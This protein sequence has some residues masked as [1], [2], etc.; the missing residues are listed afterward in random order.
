MIPLGHSFAGLVVVVA[1]EIGAIIGRMV[2]ED[3]FSGPITSAA[4]KSAQASNKISGANGAAAKSADALSTA[5]RSLAGVLG[6]GAILSGIRGISGLGA[7][8]EQTRVAL[9]V[10]LGSAEKANDVIERLNRFSNVTPFTNDQVLKAGR[11]LLAFGADAA[12]LED[13]LRKIGDV[14]AGTGKDFNELAL[15]Y[16]KAMTAGRV[17]AED[18]NQ[19]TEAGIPII[20]ELA[21]HFGVAESQVRSFASEGKISFEDL[22]A[23]FTQMTTSGGI[24]TNMMA[25]QSMTFAGL[26][27]TIE[28]TVQGTLAKVGETLNDLLKPA[29]IAIADTVLYLDNAW[30]S[31]DGNSKKAVVAFGTI[32]A[33]AGALIIAMPALA[34][35]IGVV[36]AALKAAFVTNPV[37]LVILAVASAIAVLIAYSDELATVFAPVARQM[38][39]LRES[40]SRIIQAVQ[41]AVDA[42]S[43]FID[44]IAKRF[45]SSGRR[46]V[47]LFGMALQ[48]AFAPVA[49]A[50][51]TA[52]IALRTLFDAIM[53]LA[54]GAGSPTER[55]EAAWAI[56][57]DGVKEV[58]KSTI[59]IVNSIGRLQHA[60][61]E[62][63]TAIGRLAAAHDNAASA[64]DRQSQSQHR[65]NREL[66]D[67]SKADV[68]IQ[69]G[70]PGM[71][72]QVD[73]AQSMFDRVVDITK[74]FLSQISGAID[75]WAK[76]IDAQQKKAQ[77]NFEHLNGMAS[78][79]GAIANRMAEESIA[80]VEDQ[81]NAELD[82]IRA[83]HNEKLALLDSEIAALKSKMDL[84]LEMLIE[85]ERAKFEAR[86]MQLE[87]T[88]ADDEQRRVIGAQFESDWL[89][90]EKQLRSEHETQVS[91]EL[92]QKQAERAEVVQTTANKEKA[93]EEDKSKKIDAIRKENE[94]R[95]KDTQK[96]IAFARWMTSLVGFEASKQIAR[97]QAVIQFAQM[98][99]ALPAAIMQAGATMGIPG[100]IAAAALGGTTLV[101]GAAALSATMG[102][103]NSQQ[104][105]LPPAEL[106][107]AT[108][109]VVTGGGTSTSDSVSFNA[110]LSNGE[111]MMVMDAQ[112]T[113]RMFD[114]AEGA[115]VG[116]GQ[117]MVFNFTVNGNMDE[118]MAETV[119][120]IVQNRIERRAYA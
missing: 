62:T 70:S 21:R 8:L 63:S 45:G 27:S 2:L 54:S 30:N 13:R 50:V 118:R 32:V 115:L 23:A 82:I 4:A 89:E 71:K 110:N 93:I 98:T 120:T 17:Q 109:G 28:G 15:I 119:A 117:Q 9:G 33:V 49:S 11:A 103:I 85:S 88:A 1:F 55:L 81:A 10:F 86:K 96:A 25:K 76:L 59:E 20:G 75:Q 69:G 83:A 95:E 64:A 107:M 47:S 61:A 84:E 51:S 5:M 113:Q 90:Y 38:A 37:G 72:N 66:K 46:E 111:S 94:K 114:A 24:F 104:P 34:T 12:T 112:R 67:Q 43:S 52:V 91:E 78:I 105:P 65:L 6:A 3:D 79:L 29:M 106:F 7:S 100:M 36:G 41:P 102:M 22:D 42:I 80:R 39:E 44:T 116:S 77:N 101:L 35:G 92:S 97:S 40:F 18:L 16:G 48:A 31:L 26:A 57:A 60:S 99:L 14:A 58:G 19:L 68:M 87:E 74:N 56:L 53:V 73:Q 108:G